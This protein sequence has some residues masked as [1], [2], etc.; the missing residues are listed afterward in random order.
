MGDPLLDIA[1]ASEKVAGQTVTGVSFA[2]VV[3][4]MRR[5]PVIAQLFKGSVTADEMMDAGPDAVAAILAASISRPD[6]AEAEKAL[7]VWPLGRQVELLDAAIRATFPDGVGRFRDRLLQL[8]G[9][10]ADEPPPQQP[11]GSD[12]AEASPAQPSN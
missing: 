4:L 11:A 2:G 10:L 6:D 7:T 9:V 8:A 3:K 5:F 12:A 1:P